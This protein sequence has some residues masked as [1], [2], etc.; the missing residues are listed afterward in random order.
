MMRHLLT[1]PAFPD[2]VAAAAA[3]AESELRANRSA[4]TAASS[5]S[6]ILTLTWTLLG[7]MEMAATRLW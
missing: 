5:A 1:D 4:R 7:K 2:L 3:D 6:I